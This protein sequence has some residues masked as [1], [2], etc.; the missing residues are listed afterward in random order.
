MSA[1]PSLAVVPGN[2]MSVGVTDG[3]SKLLQQ[4]IGAGLSWEVLANVQRLR[5]Q[6]QQGI[7]QGDVVLLGLDIERPVQVA[8]QVHGFDKTIP[9]LILAEPEDCAALRRTIM[10]SPLLG[11]EVTP[12]P[13]TD[14]DG[15]GQALSRAI[16]RHRQRRNYLDTIVSAQPKLGNL[17]LSQPEVGH[18]LGRL[19][20]QAPVGVISLDAQ[21]GILGINR[22]ADRI[23]GVSEGAAIG[24][25]LEDFFTPMD[26]PRLTNLLRRSA[27]AQKFGMTPEVFQSVP[28][29][30]QTRYL[31]ATAS[32]IAYRLGQRGFMVI[33][34]DVTAR[35]RAEQQRRKTEDHMRKLSGAL[36][37]AAESV[38]IT[39]E[40]R[41]IEY[42]NPAFEILTGYTKEEAIGREPYFLRSGEHGESVFQNL[43][44][45]ISDGCVF[46]GVLVNR[47]KDGSVYHEEK[48]ITPLRDSE[49]MIT[50]Y[51]S[52]GHDITERLQAEEAVR[53][54]RAELAHVARLST[55]GEM[56]SG[57]AHEL[58]QPLCAITTYTQ[59]CLR[60]LNGENYDKNKVRYGLE[61]VVKQ[62]ELAGEI[63]TRLRNFA[64][65]GELL[66][67]P[68]ILI[69]I[70]NEVA[71]LVSAEL[72]QKQITLDICND[73]ST[74]YVH[75]DPIEIEQV[76]LNLIRNSMD[77]MAELPPERC[78]LTVRIS[79]GGRDEVKVSVID[80]GCGCPEQIIERLFEPFFTTKPTGLGIGLGISQSII[81]AHGG[82][83][84]VEENSSAGATFSFILPELEIM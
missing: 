16:E 57:I 12:W 42:V 15:L 74:L 39:D 73:V 59:I 34:Q 38:M 5:M 70:V 80:R 78:K 55:L 31:E 75:V 10:F 52:T 11:S 72:S 65:K 53:R 48:T 35:E 82:R 22:Q 7:L 8:Q 36:E 46:R 58:N 26:R 30:Q 1:K 76:L 6:I 56:T 64:R 3:L 41:I 81:E 63:F 44:Q 61:N 83:L 27:V 62:A 18:Y 71:D 14:I 4:K 33:L 25:A 47:R 66:R 17:P 60:V 79:K 21:G 29:G 13:I 28:I 77:A 50:H 9:V 45:T 49:G 24:L 23:L 2:V 32:P 51:I 20:D 43:W 40:N 19:L 84:F 54:H 37:Q 68:A 69:D 67:R